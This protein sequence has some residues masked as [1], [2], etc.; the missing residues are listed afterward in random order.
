MFLP[1]VFRM[2]LL[3]RTTN[4]EQIL[5]IFIFT[6]ETH[7]RYGWLQELCLNL[8]LFLWQVVDLHLKEILSAVKP[9]SFF[10]FG[11]RFPF[12]LK[13]IVLT[14]TL[15][16]C[17]CHVGVSVLSVLSQALDFIGIFYPENTRQKQQMS[18]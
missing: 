2:K 1:L 14:I 3:E 12:L 11:M 9:F 16:P 4:A 17:H 5:S 10:F 18:V 8:Y 7:I 15:Q 13:S 6:T